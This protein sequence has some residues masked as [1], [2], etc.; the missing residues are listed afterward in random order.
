MD[1]SPRLGGWQ[2][3]SPLK[4]MAMLPSSQ[5]GAVDSCVSTK[6][7]EKLGQEAEMWDGLQTYNA[8][9]IH[10]LFLTSS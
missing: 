2:V 10:C 8:P 5:Q 9:T 7:F 3:L 6:H 4:D 1:P